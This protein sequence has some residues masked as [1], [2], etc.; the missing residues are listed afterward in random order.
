LLV[1]TSDGMTVEVIVKSNASP[2]PI[3]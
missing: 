3:G 1:N 2:A